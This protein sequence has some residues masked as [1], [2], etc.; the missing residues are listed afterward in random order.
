M[1]R[2]LAALKGAVVAA[3]DIATANVQLS[4]QYRY[5]K[6]Q[7]PAITGYQATNSVSIRFRDIARSGTILA[8][9]VKQGAN[10]IAGP[11]LSLA[12]PDAALD[13]PSADAAQN[14][15]EYTSERQTP[16]RTSIPLF[17]LN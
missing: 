6:N 11:N 16:M 4:P 5:G 7:P 9:Q 3:R 1:D 15:E 14:S 2:V 13:G 17:G 8:A 10:Q 12:S